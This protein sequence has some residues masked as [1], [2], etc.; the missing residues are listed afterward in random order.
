MN[1]GGCYPPCPVGQ[2][3]GDTQG[4]CV[5][6]KDWLVPSSDLCVCDNGNVDFESACFPACTITGQE[7]IHATQGE[8]A[9]PPGE[10]VNG[11][12]CFLPCPAG[13]EFGDIE[14]VCVCTND[15]LVPSGDLCVCADDKEEFEEACFT[16]CEGGREFVPGTT[17]GECACEGNKVMD[18][19][20]C[21]LPCDAG[22]DF[23]VRNSG[24]CIDSNCPSDS[25]FVDGFCVLYL[26]GI[27]FLLISRWRI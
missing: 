15:W 25:K 11:G 2:V 7:F 27:F 14:G 17:I 9:C 16:P 18:G 12:G 20:G 4:V 6:T 1:G 3:F 24:V 5:C 21:F 10:V 23:D 22:Q 13:Q 8:C 19:N 26:K